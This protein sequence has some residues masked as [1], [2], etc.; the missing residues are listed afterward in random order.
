MRIRA[1]SICPGVHPYWQQARQI[2]VG[3]R[4]GHTGLQTPDPIK[5]ESGKDQIA[6]VKGQWHHN[7]ETCIHQ[8]EIPWHNPDYLPR[9]RIHCN[10]AP[11]HRTVATEPP[12][13]VAVAEHR[14]LRAEWN[15]ICL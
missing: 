11:D 15:L 14:A 4:D 8:L 2:G 3:F 5:S 10:V 7:L 6:A 1:R 12:L 9:P 13:P